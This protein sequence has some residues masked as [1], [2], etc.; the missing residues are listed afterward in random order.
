MRC[1]GGVEKFK[2]VGLS[3]FESCI[4]GYLGV[5]LEGEELPDFWGQG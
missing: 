1:F 2:G 5:H 3:E 4:I